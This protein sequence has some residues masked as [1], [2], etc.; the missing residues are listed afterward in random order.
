MELRASSRCHPVGP[1]CWLL[2]RSPMSPSSMVTG[3]MESNVSI[4]LYNKLFLFTDK[5]LLHT[6]TNCTYNLN[7]ISNDRPNSPETLM[8]SAHRQLLGLRCIAS[9]REYVTVWTIDNS[10]LWELESLSHIVFSSQTVAWF[11]NHREFPI[12]QIYVDN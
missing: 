4:S 10:K 1:L 5:P 2:E 9:I 6:C 11:A 7:V 3:T 8:Y 12:I